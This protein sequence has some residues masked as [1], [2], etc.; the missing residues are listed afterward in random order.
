MHKLYSLK[1][2]KKILIATNNPGKFTELKEI[3]P[4]NIKYYKPKDF[5]LR[6][7]VENGGTFKKNAKIKSSFAAK[8]DLI[9]ALFLNVPPFSTG[10]LKLKS[11]GL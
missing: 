9:L 6:E 1:K 2:A 5:N 10:S 3:L 11:L 7:P 4:K 8:D